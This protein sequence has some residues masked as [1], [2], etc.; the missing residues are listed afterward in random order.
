MTIQACIL[1]LACAF[2]L[3]YLAESSLVE[4]IG[5]MVLWSVSAALAFIPICELVYE[6]LRRMIR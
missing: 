4:R 1:F 6:W 3:G 2:Y 5:K